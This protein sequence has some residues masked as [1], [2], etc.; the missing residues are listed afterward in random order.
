MPVAAI[1]AGVAA[2]SF[3]PVVF[4]V[5]AGLAAAATVV[6]EFASRWERTRIDARLRDLEDRHEINSAEVARVSTA[7]NNFTV[8]GPSN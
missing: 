3:S 5:V 7:V 1:S 2:I 6:G 8:A 4:P